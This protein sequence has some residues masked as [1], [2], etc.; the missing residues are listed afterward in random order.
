[1][2]HLF[3]VIKIDYFN[4]YWNLKVSVVKMRLWP[5]YMYTINIFMDPLI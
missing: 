5:Y 2:G 1:M 4:D 3:Y